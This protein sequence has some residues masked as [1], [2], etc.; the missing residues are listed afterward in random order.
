MTRRR[1]MQFRLVINHRFLLEYAKKFPRINSHRPKM[2]ISRH[3]QE[4]GSADN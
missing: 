2:R 1:R 4:Q 3:N